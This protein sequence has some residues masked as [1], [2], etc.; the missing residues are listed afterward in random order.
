MYYKGWREEAI[1]EDRRDVSSR[2]WGEMYCMIFWLRDFVSVMRAYYVK[3]YVPNG[4]SHGHMALNYHIA[5]TILHT[6]P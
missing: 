6:L 3:P 4:M 2:K 5:V 1:E